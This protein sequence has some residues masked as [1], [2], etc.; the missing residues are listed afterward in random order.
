MSDILLQYLLFLAKAVTVTGSILIIVIGILGF[1]AKQKQALKGGRLHIENLSEKIKNQLNE[2]KGM[3]FD[4]KQFK[5]LLKQEA[6]ESKNTKKTYKNKKNITNIN[7]EEPSKPRLFVLDFDGDIKASAVTEL[8]SCINAI[9]P[10]L[11][12]KHDEVL[13]KL[14]SGGG[15]V[16]AYG[17]AASQLDRL[18]QQ[19]VKLTITVDK[20]AA[21]GGYMMACVADQIIAAPFAVIGSI[22]VV[23]QIPNFHKLLEKHNIEF[24]QHTAGEYKRT[25]TMFGKNDNKAREKFKDE[26]ELTHELFKKYI[27]DRRIN[28]DIEEVATGEY[29]YGTIAKQKN[30]VDK[31]ATSDDIILDYY[32]THELFSVKYENKKSLSEKLTSSAQSLLNIFKANFTSAF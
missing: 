32:K 15:M 2:V 6:K 29:W 10:V 1:S 16:H 25:L 17:L 22:G 9:L 28:L 30:L 4:K 8:Q 27:T 23:G 19:G 11:D 13:V 3:I 26:L 14:E 18:R 24:E 20:I 21:S 5:L 31:I 7:S 12:K